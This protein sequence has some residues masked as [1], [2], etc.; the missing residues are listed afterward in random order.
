MRLKNKGTKCANDQCDLEAYTKSFCKKHYQKYHYEQKTGAVR[1]AKT[2]VMV[3]CLIA[4]C[5]ESHYMNGSCRSH[6]DKLKNKCTIV[7]Y[8]AIVG[9]TSNAKECN[10][11]ECTN[12]ADC[13]KMCVKHYNQVRVYG[14]INPKIKRVRGTKYS[15]ELHA[16]ESR[17]KKNEHNNCWMWKGSFNKG[18]P[19]FFWKRVSHK[20]HRF[21]YEHFKRKMIG[22]MR[23]KWKCTNHMTCLNPDH[24]ILTYSR[25]VGE[26]SADKY[27]KHERAMLSYSEIE[28]LKDF[29]EKEYNKNLDCGDYRYDKDE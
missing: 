29:N 7:Q 15:S 16:F 8:N 25:E 10:V 14:E 26:R 1:K 23:I 4:G 24:M 28:A 13:K 21:S 20:A 27:E 2:P 18:Y 19:V 6:W 3:S 12:I 11:E 9:Y 17:I 5:S 22:S